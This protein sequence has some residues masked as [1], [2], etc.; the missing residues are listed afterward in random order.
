MAFNFF[1]KKQL[2][3]LHNEKS[4][5]FFPAF[6]Y[7]NKEEIIL[8]LDVGSASVG[9]ALVRMK[10]GKPP[11]IISTVHHDIPFQGMLSSSRFLAGINHSLIQIF[12]KI[13]ATQYEGVIPTHIS[14]TLSSPW[15]ILKTR[16]IQI[17]KEKQFEVTEELLNSFLNDEI[18]HIK[19][20]LKDTLPL[21][22]IEI[23]EKKI[24]QT[25]LNGYQVENPYG[26]KTANIEIIATIS[27]SSQRALR[28]IRGTIG[29]FFH[30]SDLHLSVFPLTA[31]SAICDMFPYH[32]D[33]IFADISGEATDI[34]L[35]KDDVLMGTT[36]FPYGKN[37]FIREISI[38]QKT[39]QEEAITLFSMYLRGELEEKR[40]ANIK[41]VVEKSRVEWKRNF[42]KAFL[43]SVN[44][45]KTGSVMFF[46]ADTEV[47]SFFEGLMKE[48]L[49]EFF[50]GEEV[51]IKYLNNESITNFV[52]FESGV[53]RDPF[54]SIEALFSKK[55]LSH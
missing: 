55:I 27:L 24:I 16:H 12:K 5:R 10:E 38:G 18:D 52:S 48:L 8:V 50:S 51:E 30:T 33:F 44:E 40:Y 1:R 23:I 14:C 37:F 41:D 26:K 21:Q 25:K 47:A 11:H 9:A 39:S 42:K 46:T 6:L 2:G 22:D 4:R 15:F 54:L 13:Q 49:T 3:S 20:E 43:S 32:Q 36:I 28:S 34:S 17:S 45:G 31:F 19:D 35:V 53:I 7:K 29:N